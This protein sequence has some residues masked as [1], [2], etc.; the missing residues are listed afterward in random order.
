LDTSCIILAGGRSLRLGHDKVLEK[1]GDKSLLEQV[2]SR[3]DSLSREII[4][5]TA[6]ERTFP[7]LASHPKLKIVS[8]IFPG[9]G[10]LGGIYTGLV[11]SNSFYNLVVACDMP[12]MSQPL[13]RY[14]IEVSDGFDF[15]L[16]RVNNLFEPLHAVYSK[17][18]IAP[19]ESLLKQGR[20]VIVELFDFVKVR[21]I[22]AEEIDRFDPQH[23]SFFN[24][25]TQ[26]DL[27]LARKIARGDKA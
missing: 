20:K 4:I 16:P 17:K 26:E 7:Q 18:C 19:I 23:L 24:I 12:F 5:V 3:I 10:S 2:I 13:L 11:T 14:M 1:V 27:E 8:D 9:R 6:K 21:Y 25:N 15:V 22:E